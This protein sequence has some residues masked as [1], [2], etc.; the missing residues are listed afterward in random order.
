M[1][2]QFVR[3][4]KAKNMQCTQRPNERFIDTSTKDVDRRANWDC[5]MILGS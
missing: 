1:W 2:L 4:T 5:E 3:K